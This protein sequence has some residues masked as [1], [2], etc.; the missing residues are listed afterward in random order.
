MTALPTL[1][2]DGWATV[3]LEG[4]FLAGPS[5]CRNTGSFLGGVKSTSSAKKVDPWLSKKKIAFESLHSQGLRKIRATYL[6][7]LEDQEMS[8]SY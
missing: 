6:F 7:G 3:V 4:C 1:V 2:G 5:E 8:M